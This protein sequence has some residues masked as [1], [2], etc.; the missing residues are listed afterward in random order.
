[1]RQQ[2]SGGVTLDQVTTVTLT[3]LDGDRATMA[4]DITQ[5]PRADVWNLP[6]GAGML[7][8]EEYLMHGTGT[9]TLDLGLPLPVD[10]RIETAGEQQYRDPQSE[11]TLHQSTSSLVQWGG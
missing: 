4:L 2:I 6:D 5:T 8:I 9:M 7:D 11:S 1:V 3:A 10:A